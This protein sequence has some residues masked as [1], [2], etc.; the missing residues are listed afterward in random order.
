MTISVPAKTGKTA[1]V[2]IDRRRP[3]F[4]PKK[5]EMI[6]KNIPPI[7][8]VPPVQAN[9]SPLDLV[10]TVVDINVCWPMK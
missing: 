1:N 3:K 7:L 4:F 10:A 6:G 8:H 9:A 2:K 5:P